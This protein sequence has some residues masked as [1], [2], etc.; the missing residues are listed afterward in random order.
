MEVRTTPLSLANYRGCL[1]ATRIK[2]AVPSFET[3]GYRTMAVLDT[4]TLFQ[5]PRPAQEWRKEY[6]WLCHR[7]SSTPQRP[8][9]VIYTSRSV[10]LTHPQ[11]PREHREEGNGKRSSSRAELPGFE[12]SPCH[13]LSVGLGASYLTSLDL[14]PHL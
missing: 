8:S 14:F 2:A 4:A 5:V 1:P 6:I 7:N 10:E 11:K 12:S 3:L 9:F 13:L